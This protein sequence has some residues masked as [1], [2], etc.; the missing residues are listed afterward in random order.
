MMEKN[1]LFVL[2]IIISIVATATTDSAL[3]Y[4]VAAHCQLSLDLWNS[5]RDNVIGS[6]KILN[7]ISSSY[8]MP[9]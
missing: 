8:L 6:L 3:G 5:T 2:L 4:V 7:S 1:S 9:M